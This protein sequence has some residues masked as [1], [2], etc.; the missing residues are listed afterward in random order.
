MKNLFK[1]KYVKERKDDTIKRKTKIRKKITKKNRLPVL[2]AVYIKF[3]TN[4]YLK[5][6]ILSHFT[7]YKNWK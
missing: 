5:H 2:K 6:F 3:N 7:F 1:S 4:P